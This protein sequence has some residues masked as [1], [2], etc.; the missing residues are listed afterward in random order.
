MT[1][2]EMA[3]LHARCFTV[4]RPWG[5]FEIRD[6][7]ATVHSF[8]V[9]EPGGFAIARVIA[10]EAELLTLAVL[11]EER[12]RGIGRR[13]LAKVIES[14]RAR[15]AGRLMLEVALDN[16]A[17]N[18]LYATAGFSQVARRGGYYHAPGHSATDALILSL[19]LSAD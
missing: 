14:A 9:T 2:A 8:A 1:H 7:L 3:A 6:I 18:A 16:S 13:L 12:R 5:E 15:G 17:A 10:G 11:P 4:P 19:P